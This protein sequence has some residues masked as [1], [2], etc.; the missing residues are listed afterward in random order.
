MHGLLSVRGKRRSMATLQ[1]GIFASGR[2]S[3]FQAILNAIQSQVLDAQ[4]KLVVSNTSQAGVLDTAK[5]AGLSY[6][7]INRKDFENRE[8]F[9]EDLMETLHS[10]DVDFVALAG[11]MKKIPPEVIAQ[12]QWRMV[13]VHPALLPAF[14]G[15]G[16]YGSR[17]H[18]AVLDAGCK[19]SGV[20]IHMV[21]EH[22]DHGPIV[23]QKCVPVMGDDSAY[24]LAA[25][26]LKVEH[27]LYPETLQL[28]AEDCVHVIDRRAVVR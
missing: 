28:F 1:L 15:Q 2:G 7:V 26:I 14:G 13:N 16:M 11:Y 19:V 18:Q 23:A 10:H 5:K 21:D 6:A 27:R 3:N 8:A 4:V 24:T 22:Y 25:R 20:T 12:Y 9:V 17:V